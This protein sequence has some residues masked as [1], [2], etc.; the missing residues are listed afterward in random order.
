MV[1]PRF[2]R[3]V[4]ASFAVV[5]LSAATLIGATAA[6]ASS[7][8][9]VA[10]PKGTDS[11]TCGAIF[12][13]CRT[14]GQAVTN[15]PVGAKIIAHPGTYPEQVVVTKQLTLVGLAATIDATG[16]DNGIQLSGPGASGSTVAGFTVENAT[17]EGILASGVDGVTIA[18]NHLS[19]NDLGASDPSTAY[20]PCQASGEI[21]GDCGEGL[22]IQATTNSKV[23]W[24][25][26][27]HNVGGILISDDFAPTH[28]NL[29]A[30]NNASNNAEDCG[31][32]LP[33]H[34]PT[35]GVYDNRIERNFSR[36]N[37]GAGVLVAAAGP[38]MKAYDNV[39]TR[40]IISG[41]GEGGIQLH[42]HAP[43]Q[44]ID[45]NQITE[46]WI[47]T[48]N[49]AGDPDS[50]D[51]ETTGIIVFSAVVPVTGTVIRN[52]FIAHDHFGLW[53]S[54]NVDQSGVGFNRFIDVAVPV[55]P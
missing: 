5:A 12:Q 2:G 55:G 31:I 25:D 24:N 45:G 21:P 37:G 51:L 28:G 10:S 17:G 39:I 6:G 22:H 4:A 47:G 43:G 11:S 54:A 32:T 34:D 18:Y 44:S 13:P 49:T 8:V 14:I 9:F 48:N 29:I 40:N 52:N 35:G 1:N 46:N 15:A 42:A 7:A 20:P 50:G 30:H 23:L 26:V 33:A 3:A 41:N 36:N 27:E 19:G 16:H 38:D 53:L